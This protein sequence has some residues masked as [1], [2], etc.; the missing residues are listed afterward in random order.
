MSIRRLNRIT[1]FTLTTAL[2]VIAF[3]S[4]YND[5]GLIISVHAD[6]ADGS[7]GDTAADSATPT[8]AAQQ[9]T[10]Q[11][12]TEAI[13]YA[14]LSALT[15][16]YSQTMKEKKEVQQK[17]ND[18]MD[19][20]NSFITKLRE[21]DEMIIDY[22]NKIDD[23]NSRTT[24]AYK[25]MD[26]LSQKVETAETK[27][28]EEYEIIKK[29]ISQEYEN[30]SASY[31]D[32]FFNS[33]DYVDVVNKSEY[34]QAMDA[35]NNKVIN[36]MISAERSFS[37]QK[38]LLGG[39]TEDLETL[40]E[41]YKNDQEI[42]QKLSDEKEKQISFFNGSINSTKNE[43]SEIEKI[44]QDQA[45][46]IAAMERN[47]NTTLNSTSGLTTTSTFQYNGE[48][49]QWPVPSSTTI[50]SYYGNRDKPNE[51]ASSNHQ[52]IDISCTSGAEVVAA[53]SGVIS[54][55]EY[56]GNYG[57]MI[58]INHGSHITTLY[59]HLSAYAVASGDKVTKGQVIGYAGMTG[60]VTGPHLHFGV[61]EEGE[62]VDPLKY[63]P[64]LKQPSDSGVGATKN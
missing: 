53:A 16:E 58:Q 26:V 27:R 12:T 5:K 63:Y 17:L 1:A 54:M 25:M 60:N 14:A 7:S 50:S 10:T 29:Y 55:A 42:L 44:E 33:T 49:F 32:T 46:R 57:N 45:A 18:L 35:Y 19:S 52:G 21:L 48:A 30:N 64:A 62:Y 23:I 38:L 51:A 13:D 47:S 3:G 22:Q 56:N 31:I 15:N 28:N 43:L 4:V 20:Q 36:K 6:E 39:L 34:I 11:V 2:S 59:A 9:T 24:Q 61:R 37:D 40:D 41:A 8:D